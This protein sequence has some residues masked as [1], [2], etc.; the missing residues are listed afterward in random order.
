MW[1]DEIADTN[2]SSGFNLDRS[3]TAALSVVSNNSGFP[4]IE[5]V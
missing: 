4:F 5:T 2:K 3:P 1:Q